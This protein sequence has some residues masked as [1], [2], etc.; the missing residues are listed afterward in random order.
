MT[1]AVD[2]RTWTIEVPQP[3]A[4]LTANIERDWRKRST[5]VRTWRQAVVLACQAAKLPQGIS[6]VELSAVIYYV[7]RSPVRDRLNLAP[8][9]KACVDALTPQVVKFRKGKPVISIGYGFL[10]DDSD[11]HVLETNWYL[12]PAKSVGRTVSAVVLTIREVA[13]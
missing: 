1:A 13:P 7:G 6:P 2:T 4:W 5:L 9:I 12:D 8:T 3:C 11:R 10:P